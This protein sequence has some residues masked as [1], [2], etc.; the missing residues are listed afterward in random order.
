M[1][2]FLLV[3]ALLAISAGA[4]Q[5][6]PGYYEGGPRPRVGLE[7][8]FGLQAGHIACESE[9]DFCDGYT[10][11]GGLNL[12]AAYFLSPSFGLALDLW[13]MARTEDN[14]TFTHYVNTIGI[15]WRPVPI[16]TLSA[17]IGSAHA[18]YDY[19]GVIQAQVTSGDAFAVMGAA[20]LDL[21]GGR[22]WALSVE[23]RFGNGF[24]G[25]DNDNGTAD[26]VGRNVGF[27]VGLTFFRF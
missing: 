24:Y 5:A 22:H 9:G 15:K 21:I 12:N 10:K 11:A 19:D 26:I 14:F 18:T 20:S 16:L 17:G 27:G 23:A 13:A 8:G 7:L 1:R 3:S 25:D 2:S 4:A 6:Q